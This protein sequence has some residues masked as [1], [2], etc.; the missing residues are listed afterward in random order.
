MKYQHVADVVVE[1]YSCATCIGG[2]LNGTTIHQYLI[3][4][5]TKIALLKSLN[6]VTSKEQNS[7]SFLRHWTDTVKKEA[8]ICDLHRYRKFFFS[9]S[10]KNNGV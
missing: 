5:C 10:G 6:F 8:E 4:F 9:N 3:N 7:R 2:G 1:V